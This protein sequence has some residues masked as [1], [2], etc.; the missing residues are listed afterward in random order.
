MQFEQALEMLLDRHAVLVAVMYLVAAS[1][2]LILAASVKDAVKK[3]FF[4]RESHT[5]ADHCKESEK[6]FAAGEEHIAENHAHIKELREGQRVCCVSLMALLE[7]AIHNG[8][9]TE[10]E[11]ASAELKN[12][13]VNRK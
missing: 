8:N 1:V 12:Y 11:N 9:K 10:M 2:L 5:L 6:R 13:L 7:Y 3:L 4:R